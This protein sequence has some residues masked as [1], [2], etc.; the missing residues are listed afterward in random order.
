MISRFNNLISTG[1]KTNGEVSR[2]VIVKEVFRKE[3]PLFVKCESHG[4]YGV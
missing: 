3:V 2:R 4:V 1:R